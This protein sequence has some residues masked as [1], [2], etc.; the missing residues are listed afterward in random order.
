[1][2]RLTILVIGAALLSAACGAR[3]ASSLGPI[4]TSDPSPSPSGPGSPTP[5]PTDPTSSPSPGQTLT[6]EL[7]LVRDGSLFVTQRTEAFTVAVGQ[8]AIDGLLAGPNGVERDAQVTTAI[9]SG[10]E[11]D[12]TDLTGDGLATVDMSG[13]FF[14][15]DMETV[16]L[17]QAQVVY[18]LT[19]FD[20][21]RRVMFTSIDGVDVGDD[22]RTRKEFEDVL[23]PI[24]VQSPIIGARVDNPVTISGTANVF[25]AT[26]SVRIL[27]SAGNEVA[28][29]F[30]TATCGTGCRGDY[31]ISVRYDVDDE[32][33]GTIEVFE[34][35]ALDGSMIHVQSI[36]VTL[37][38]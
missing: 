26:V 29:T 15:S 28:R 11:A 17:R 9:P 12:I 4:P 35:S 34:S 16:R 3:G 27:D 19:Q 18:T 23:P 24:L 21:I 1:V 7:W 31:S 10:V 22:A 8:R 5:D 20:T 33:A 13:A 14:Q 30:T 6:Y 36:P 37:T 25:E 38:P 2:K 32:Q